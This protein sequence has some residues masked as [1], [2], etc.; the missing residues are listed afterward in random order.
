MCRPV[1]FSTLLSLQS[2]IHGWGLIA[3]KDMPKDS[4]V[5][6]YRAQVVR[7]SV[8]DKRER[9][10]GRQGIECYF[11]GVNDDTVMDSTYCGSLARFTVRRSCAWV[12]TSRVPVH[13]PGRVDVSSCGRNLCLLPPA[14]L[15]VLHTESLLHAVDVHPRYRDVAWGLA[16]AVV[17]E[18]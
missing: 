5:L 18:D 14:C 16:L 10:Y 13:A 6:E 2:G 15:H 17:C 8:A 4:M 3:R 9:A 7:R 11:F 1:N 12:P